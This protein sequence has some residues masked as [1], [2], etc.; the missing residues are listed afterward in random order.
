V[1]LR[2]QL[3]CKRRGG[4]RRGRQRIEG[5]E[6]GKERAVFTSKYFCQV[7]DSGTCFGVQNIGLSNYKLK[8]VSV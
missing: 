6:K 7:G 3:L 1:D 5:V 2:A 4:K 8:S